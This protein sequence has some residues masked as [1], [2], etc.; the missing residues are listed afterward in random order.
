MMLH[1]NKIN[2]APVSDSTHFCSQT[3]SVQRTEANTID[4]RV[5][6]VVSKWIVT[7]KGAVPLVLA[8]ANEITSSDQCCDM[9][10]G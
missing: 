10:L 8:V 1:S 3:G 6:T 7:F 5:V 9:G 4:S 2:P